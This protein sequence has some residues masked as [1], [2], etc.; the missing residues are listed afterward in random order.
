VEVQANTSLVETR[1]V[2]VGSVM[3]L[4]RIEALPLNGRNAQELV[5]LNG[6]AQQVAPVGGY[7]VG[8]RLTISVAGSFGT[9][10]DYNLD[11]AR[12]IDPFDGLALALPFPDALAEFKTEIGGQSAS[13]GKSGQVSAVTKSGTNAFHGDLFEFVRNDLFNATQYFAR[14]DPASGNKVH[15]TLKRN[16]FGGTIGGPIIKNKLFFFGGY[17][18]TTI[19][20]DPSNLKSFVPTPAMMAGDFTAFASKECNARGA[21]TLKA[22]FVNNRIDPNLLDPVAVKLVNGYLPKPDDACGQVTYGK[23]NPIDDGQ[24]VVKLDFQQSAKHSMFGRYLFTTEDNLH[25]ATGANVLSADVNRYDKTK[26]I[27]FG[28]TY[29]IGASM[30]NSFRLALSQTSQDTFNPK[31][32]S[33]GVLGSKVYDYVKDA[34]NLNITSGFTLGANTRRIRSDLYQLN[35]DVSW[36][37]GAHQ[38]GFGGRIAENRTIGETGDTILPN[39]AFSGDFTGTGLSDFLTGKTSQ[40]IQGLGSGNYLRTRYMSLYAQDTWQMRPRF[41]VNAGLRWAPVLPLRDFR[42]PVPNVSNFYEDRFLAG[43]RSQTFVNAPPGFVYSGDPQLVQNNAGGYA[44]KPEA[45]LWKPY[46]KEFAPRLGFAWDVRGDGR[47]SLRASYGVNFEEYG[48][49]YR[50]GT[51]QQQP[52]WGSS[53]TLIAPVGGLDDPWAGIPGGNPHPLTLNQSMTFVPQGTYQPNNPDLFP[54]YT[55]TWNL[56]LQREVVKNTVLSVAYLG[57][58]ITHLQAAQAVNPSIYIPGNG[59]ANGNCAYN[60]GI[61]P[62]KVAP[63]APCSTLANTQVRR[64]L[65]LLRPQ[66]ASEIGKFGIIVNG[67]TQNYHGMLLSYQQRAAKGVTVTANYTLSHCI[68]DYAGRSQAGYGTSADQTYQDAN[69]RRRDRGDCEVDARHIFNITALG[70]SPKFANHMLSL[71]AS[72]WKLSTLSR[73]HGGCERS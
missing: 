62:F 59:D 47:T 39:F 67:G 9:S 42:R 2:S 57:T 48:S 45:D 19:R 10:M 7:S 14:V 46:W 52:P 6:A 31:T 26:G 33:W 32:V 25:P 4:G 21:L 40:F 27:T 1:S 61:A 72:G 18:G 11:G 63:G 20:Q 37:R 60:G 30:V 70:E 13:A 66:Y 28:S 71:V 54:T 12:H 43:I 29:L 58:Q 15:S 49:L 44:S 35:D 24:T 55:Q 17:Q 38:F 68:G 73:K 5:I 64:R 53:T 51:S 3:E 65:S 56:S 34:L 41:T 69:N 36:T 16:Q 23:A 50:L 22:P 8:G